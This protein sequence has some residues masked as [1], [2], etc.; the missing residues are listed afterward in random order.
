M[1]KRSQRSVILVSALVAIV[2]ASAVTA[3]MAS[4][5][6][7]A[8]RPNATSK[9]AVSARLDRIFRVLQ[10]ANVRAHGASVATDAQPLPAAVVEGL[11]HQVGMEPSAAVFAGGAYATWVVP[12]STEVCL[13]HEALTP[14]DVPG[15]VCGSIQAAE[16]G[17]AVT[18][19][20]A[21]GAPVIL[22][23][24][25]DGNTSVKVTNADGTTESVPVTNNVYEIASGEPISVTLKEASGVSETRHLATLSSSP[26]SAPADSPTP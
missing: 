13:M 11:S 25:P 5:E 10:R 21:A 22:G 9:H 20:D 23:L 4:S 18:S 14:Q 24:A 19:E 8:A 15:G 6:G 2:A 16:H 12:G 26:A 3:A 17:L 7:H 1:I